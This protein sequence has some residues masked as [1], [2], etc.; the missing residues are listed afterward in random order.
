MSPTLGV[1]ID[2]KQTADGREAE[3]EDSADA[4]DD[5]VSGNPRSFSPMF[6][7]GRRDGVQY[8]NQENPISNNYLRGPRS[9]GKFRCPIKVAHGRIIGVEGD[10]WGRALQ[11]LCKK[12]ELTSGKASLN[13]LCCKFQAWLRL[14]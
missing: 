1:G 5:V 10:V 11:L 7:K 4:G 9:I 12:C 14:A 8:C 13:L 2:G 3:A 6:G